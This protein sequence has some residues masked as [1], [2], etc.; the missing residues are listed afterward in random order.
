MLL[1]H[2]SWLLTHVITP[3]W[4]TFVPINIYILSSAHIIILLCKHKSHQSHTMN[5]SSHYDKKTFYRHLFIFLLLWHEICSQNCQNC[6]NYWIL[7]K[8]VIGIVWGQPYDGKFLWNCW[9]MIR[10]NIMK[11]LPYINSSNFKSLTILRPSIKRLP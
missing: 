9:R 11:N 7:V 8:I 1:P 6:F 5:S 4:P 3:L 2:L 10:Q